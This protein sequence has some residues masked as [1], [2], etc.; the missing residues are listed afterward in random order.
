MTEPRTIRMTQFE[1]PG[2][3]RLAI[4]ELVEGTKGQPTLFALP[5]SQP[6]VFVG[7]RQHRLNVG[8]VPMR[9]SGYWYCIYGKFLWRLEVGIP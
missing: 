5:L 8:G 1:R 6:G 4:H 7:L 3:L 9:L 2:D